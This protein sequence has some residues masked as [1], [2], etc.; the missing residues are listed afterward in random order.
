MSLQAD[1]L[2]VPDAQVE[3]HH[4]E[5][6]RLGGAEED[7]AAATFAPLLNARQ[8]GAATVYAYGD[9]LVATLFRVRFHADCRAR[10]RQ[11]D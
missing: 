3:A 2:D 8:A 10:R 9:A 4:F 1:G 7:A 6:L 5:N 11:N